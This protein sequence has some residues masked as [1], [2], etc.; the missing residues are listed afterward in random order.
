MQKI[1][2]I[3]TLVASLNVNAVLGII[4]IYMNTEYRIDTP[5]IGSIASTLTF[6][7]EDIKATGANT[8]LDFLATVPSVGLVDVSGN[9]PALYMRG[10]NSNHT[11]VLIDGVK[12][13]GAE[14]TNGAIEYGLTNIALNDIEKVEIVK[15]SGSVL[16]GSSAVAGVISITTKKGAN[17][18]RAIVSTKFGTNNTKAYALLASSGDKEGFVRFTHNKH[19]TDGVNAHTLDLSNEKD[20]I[21]NRS[22]QIKFGNQHF[23]ASYSVANNKTNYDNPFAVD[24]TTGFSERDLTKIAVNINKK[25]SDIWKA[26]LSIAQTQHNRKNEW[27]NDKFKSADITILNHIKIDDSLLNVGLSQFNDEN[28]TDSDKLSSRD[29]FANWQKNID[30]I[31]VNVGARHIK[32]DNFATHTIYNLGTAKYFDNALKLTSSYATAFNAPSLIQLFG[33]W[34]AN[35]DLKPEISKTFELGIEKQHNWGV[36]SIRLYNNK[37]KNVIGYTTSYI[38]MHK[39][40]VEGIELS[41]NANITGYNIDFSHNYNQSRTND[42]TTQS[43]RRPKNTSNLTISKQYGKFNSRMQVIKKSSS[44]DTGNIELAGYTLLNLSTNYDINNN[45]KVS[46]NIKNATNKDYTIVN[47]YNQLSRTIEVGLDYN[48]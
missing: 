47:G 32:H 46:L 17:G 5:V 22:T 11:L 8:F 38:N 37:S 28:V 40:K 45:A 30:S 20:A 44:L 24:I 2:P 12:V 9:V 29:F 31:D 14:S 25:F 7:T 39:L 27:G 16:Y 19:T 43:I 13:N 33:D 23:N 42:E 21:S 15:G 10:S 36:S 41:A 48:F 4:P 3:V 35:P 34:G 26:K 6:N 18:E 1:L